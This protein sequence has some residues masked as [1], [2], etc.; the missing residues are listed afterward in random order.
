M[1]WP[2]MAMVAM[3]AVVWRSSASTD[4]YCTI[5]NMAFVVL[6]SRISVVFRLWLF[7]VIF[8]AIKA[9]A[10]QHGPRATAQ[11]LLV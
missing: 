1:M 5:E 2:P 8:R 10:P 9:H 3:M 4:K 11:W 6:I 7:C